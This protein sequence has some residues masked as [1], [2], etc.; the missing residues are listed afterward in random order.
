VLAQQQGTWLTRRGLRRKKYRGVPINLRLAD[1]YPTRSE[2]VDSIIKS[3]LE[4]AS[5]EAEAILF[6]IVASSSPK[7]RNRV[8]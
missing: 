5:K 2:T 8:G 3:V 7:N 4:A 6:I 1:R